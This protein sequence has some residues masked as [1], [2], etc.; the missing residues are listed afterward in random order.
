MICRY[1]SLD[2]LRHTPSRADRMQGPGSR[3]LHLLTDFDDMI[4]RV[5]DINSNSL[6]CVYASV[7]ISL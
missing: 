7:Y 3:R 4:F 5:E 1:C 2:A 6:Q